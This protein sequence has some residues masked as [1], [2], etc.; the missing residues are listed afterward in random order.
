M[1]AP[2]G[3]LLQLGLEQ[4]LNRVKRATQAYMRDRTRQA[5]G[6]VTSYAVAA[7]L[8]ATAGIFLIAACIVGLTALFRWV[9]MTYGLFTAFAVVGGIFVVLAVISAVIAA[10]KLRSPTPHYPSLGSRLRVAIAAPV[11][12]QPDSD[13]IDPDTIPLAPSSTDHTSG[14]AGALGRVNVPVGVAVAALLLGVA[15]LRRRQR[16]ASE[17]S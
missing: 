7:G 2:P 1:L 6:T 16:N 12:R 14:R 9:E 17:A 5:T 15:A 4:R 13:D 10:V 11:A 3:E 8:F